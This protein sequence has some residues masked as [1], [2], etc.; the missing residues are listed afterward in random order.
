[1]LADGIELE[2]VARYF[3]MKL[4]DLIAMMTDYNEQWGI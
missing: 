3:Q 4:P 1:M 2:A